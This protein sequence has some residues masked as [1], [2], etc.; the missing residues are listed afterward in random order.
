MLK[1]KHA[2]YALEHCNKYPSHNL[3]FFIKK[4]IDCNHTLL[5]GCCLVQY[6]ETKDYRIIYHI[7]FDNE[8]CDFKLSTY[9]NIRRWFADK[10]YILMF[11]PMCKFKKVIGIK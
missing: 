8:K 1:P 3:K 10:K 11:E 9:K 6:T 2:L 5:N 7:L 4:S